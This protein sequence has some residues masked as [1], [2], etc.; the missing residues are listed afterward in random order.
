MSG[1]PSIDSIEPIVAARG[2]LV[3][4]VVRGSYLQ[5][6]TV[7]VVPVSP[8]STPAKSTRIDSIEPERCCSMRDPGDV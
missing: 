7:R 8:G 2:S 6:G 4:L 1:L 5:Q 3:S